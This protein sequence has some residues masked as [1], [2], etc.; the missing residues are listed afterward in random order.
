MSEEQLKANVWTFFASAL[1]NLPSE[2]RTA[3]AWGLQFMEAHNTV[4]EKM[5]GWAESREASN[6][7]QYVE[8]YLAWYF[9]GRPSKTPVGVAQQS[10]PQ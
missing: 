6:K 8:G 9:C 10:R 5:C 1:P 2:E 3:H 7:R 4:R